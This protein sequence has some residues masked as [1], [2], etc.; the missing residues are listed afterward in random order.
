MVPGQS[1]TKSSGFKL[2]ACLCIESSKHKQASSRCPSLPRVFGETAMHVLYYSAERPGGIERQTRQTKKKIGPFSY[3][4][5]VL[6]LEVPPV[7]TDS[8]HDR[9]TREGGRS[10][11]RFVM[12]ANSSS[13]V[14]YV[15]ATQPTRPVSASLL[16]EACAQE[17]QQGSAR[18][19][20][21]PAIT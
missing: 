19:A 15:V 16:H 9:Y 7:Y 2:V 17:A 12:D 8:R 5:A 20:Q 14:E 6:L 1:S 11:C 18:H 21:Q 3:R 10:I 4:C 13:P